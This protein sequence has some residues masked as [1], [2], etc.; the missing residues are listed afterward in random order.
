MKRKPDVDYSPGM[1]KTRCRNCVNFRAPGACIKV[2]GL[3]DPTYWC[4]LF[5]P[6]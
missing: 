4:K 2:W 1:G 5:K 6:K 3:I